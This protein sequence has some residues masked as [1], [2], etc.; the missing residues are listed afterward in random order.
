[1]WPPLGAN[2]SDRGEGVKAGGALF[3]LAQQEGIRRGPALPF[4]NSRGRE[5]LHGRMRV[6]RLSPHTEW[7]GRG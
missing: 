6:H 3:L 2:K 7:E 1:M 4:W 5:S